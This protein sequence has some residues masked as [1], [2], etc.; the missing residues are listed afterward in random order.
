MSGMTRSMLAVATG[1]SLI[2]GCGTTTRFAK[3]NPAPRPMVPR[4]LSSVQVF[5]ASMPTRPYVEVGIVQG[6]RSSEYSSHG[7][8]Q[9]INE[10]K[11]KAA[12][13]G[14][15]ALVVK[16]PHSAVQSDLIGV[17]LDTHTLSTLEG[18][19]GVCVYWRSEQVAQTSAPKP[20]PRV[21]APAKPPRRCSP[22]FC[23]E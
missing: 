7:M 1:I 10:M 9:I 8:P 16:G 22:G 20:A 14:C 17:L 4:P 18:F 19:W 6:R 23:D 13:L 15:D 3:I 2:A 21:A 11:R 5:A 12:R